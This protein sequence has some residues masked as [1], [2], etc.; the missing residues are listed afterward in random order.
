MLFR[1]T[2]VK[3]A[4]KESAAEEDEVMPRVTKA[5][6]AGD[7]RSLDRQGERNLYLLVQG[8]DKSWRFPQGSWKEGELLH[9]VCIRTTGDLAR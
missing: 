2:A 3:S 5:D 6:L 4:S 7:V 1:S 9:E 8:Q